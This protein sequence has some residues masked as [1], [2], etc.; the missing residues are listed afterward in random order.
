MLEGCAEEGMNRRV[1]PKRK[2][3]IVYLDPEDRKGL[4]GLA[5]KTGAPLTELVRRAIKAYVKQEA[6]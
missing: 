5:T 3:L 1:T 2:P 4:D 6:K